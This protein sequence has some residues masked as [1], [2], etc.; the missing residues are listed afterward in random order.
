[1]SHGP[2]WRCREGVRH[3]PDPGLLRPVAAQETATRG[4]LGCNRLLPAGFHVSWFPG[5][6]P[7]ACACEGT[8]VS[9]PLQPGPDAP[10]TPHLGPAADMPTP[11]RGRSRRG[12]RRPRQDQPRFPGPR[13]S[14]PDCSVTLC[15]TCH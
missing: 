9:S 10:P 3:R 15:C 6:G 14:N 8:P 1:M 13:A 12:V 11:R 2:A 5:G 4:F 7:Y